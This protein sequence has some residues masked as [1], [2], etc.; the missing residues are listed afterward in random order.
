MCHILSYQNIATL[1][2]IELRLSSQRVN[3]LILNFRHVH[4]EKK[5]NI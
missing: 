1:M 4:M 2:T 3:I 5:V